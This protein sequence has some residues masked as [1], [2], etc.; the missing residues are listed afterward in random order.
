MESIVT[1][2]TIMVHVDFER[3]NNACL[4][5][6][7]DLAEQFGAKLIGIAA[8]TMQVP[9]EEDAI[10]SQTVIE[11]LRSQSAKQM[12]EAEARFRSAAGTRPRHV[13]WR[14]A[15][16]WPMGFIARE[17]RVADLIIAGA[18]RD[19]LLPF[20]QPW[21]L[22]PGDLVMQAGRPVLV[23]PPDA[24]KLKLKCAMIAWKDTREARSAVNNALPLLHK[25]EEVV[26]VEVI[27]NES[28]RTAA[29]GALDDVVSWLGHH[30]IEASARVF[31]FPDDQQP[32]KKL[33][34]YGADFIVA[35]AYGH[36]RVR[37]WVFGGFTRDLLMR[38][39]QCAFLAH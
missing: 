5:I 8:F 14:S 31:H 9:F 11:D 26:V 2:S 4:P 22:D 19:G 12:M 7:V 17:A 25:V 13:E 18:N 16:A 35:G 30:G 10:L 29:H 27:E 20:D 39:S 37:E 21:R 24:G 36:A 38:S 15:M 34:Q 3:S 33:W 1:F 32:M 23:V 6:A 28:D